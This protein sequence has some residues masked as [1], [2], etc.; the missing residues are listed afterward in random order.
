MPKWLALNT[1][2][3]RL[4]CLDCVVRHYM[5]SMGSGLIGS[6]QSRVFKD[7]FSGVGLGECFSDG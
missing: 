4:S 3:E 5:G 2:W 7:G 1:C 6:F